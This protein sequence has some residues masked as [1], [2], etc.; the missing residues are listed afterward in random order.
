MIDRYIMFDGKYEDE[1]IKYSQPCI[2]L[3]DDKTRNY[4]PE[5]ALIHARQ[6]QIW[7]TDSFYI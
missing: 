1:I 6:N 3:M 7:V 4:C 2:V 5:Y